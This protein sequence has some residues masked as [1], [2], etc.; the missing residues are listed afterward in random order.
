MQQTLSAPCTPTLLLSPGT[1]PLTALAF[2]WLKEACSIQHYTSSDHHPVSASLALQFTPVDPLP[3]PCT[4]FRR[5]T[6]PK[7]R[8]MFLTSAL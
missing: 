5:L 1:Q 6:Q 3:Q 2:F 4:L 7:E 8:K